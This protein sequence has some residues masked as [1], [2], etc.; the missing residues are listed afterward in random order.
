V[1]LATDRASDGAWPIIAIRP[2]ALPIALAAV[3]RKLSAD[4]G[5][6]LGFFGIFLRT[7]ASRI[8]DVN[9]SRRA[10]SSDPTGHGVMYLTASGGSCVPVLRG[11]S[12][13]SLV[14]STYRLGGTELWFSTCSNRTAAAG[15]LTSPLR[16]SRFER[17]AP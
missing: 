16:I 7:I 13:S 17:S 14:G 8:R 15:T 11:N 3:I 10:F 1:F 12:A 4:S 2:A 9:V 5:R 6:V